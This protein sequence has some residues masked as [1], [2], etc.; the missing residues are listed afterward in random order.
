MEKCLAYSRNSNTLAFFLLYLAWDEWQ[1]KKGSD[2]R[3]AQPQA[4]TEGDVG[5]W[6]TGDWLWIPPCSALGTSEIRPGIQ[7][8]GVFYSLL[9]GGRKRSSKRNSRSYCRFGFPVHARCLHLQ[10]ETQV[11]SEWLVPRARDL[12]VGFVSLLTPLSTHSVLALPQQAAFHK[13]LV[14]KPIPAVSVTEGQSD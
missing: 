2:R 10:W 11:H 12:W 3:R 5:S 13:S 6:V 7:V 1:E 14:F 4:G 9:Q 8:C